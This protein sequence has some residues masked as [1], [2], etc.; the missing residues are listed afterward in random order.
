[1]LKNVPLSIGCAI[2]GVMGFALFGTTFILPQWTQN[3]LGY[4]ALEAGM[5]LLPRTIVMFFMM[6]IIGRIYNHINPRVTVAIALVLLAFS[7]W[8]LGHFPLTVGFWNFT[9]ML[10]LMGVA[11]AIGMVPLSTIAMTSVTNPRMPTTPTT[12]PITRPL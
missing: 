11:L 3:L 10:V 9:P 2:G 6:P 1:M 12:F 7:T 4:P 8:S 5:V